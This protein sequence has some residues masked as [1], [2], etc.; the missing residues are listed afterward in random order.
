M[1]FKEYI[2]IKDLDYF[3][4]FSPV[5]KKIN[6]TPFILPILTKKGWFLEQQDV[7]HAFLHGVL[8]EAIYMIP[9]TKFT[10]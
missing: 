5:K 6:S 9:T 1:V 7:N 8:Q 4:T 10:Y 2:Q 3:E